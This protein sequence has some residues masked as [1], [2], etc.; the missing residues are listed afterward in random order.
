MTLTDEQVALDLHRQ[1]NG[2]R[3]PKGGS[4]PSSRI[5]H[6]VT[7]NICYRHSIMPVRSASSTCNGSIVHRQPS[8]TSGILLSNKSH[9]HH[10][11]AKAP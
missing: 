5:V 4:A 2:R 3:K 11:A 1:L 9:G 6:K 10:S 7:C 8:C